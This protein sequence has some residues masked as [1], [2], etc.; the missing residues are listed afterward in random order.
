[1]VFQLNSGDVNVAAGDVGGQ[2]GE[3]GG[4][5]Q[6]WHPCQG[7]AEAAARAAYAQLGGDPAELPDMIW[8]TPLRTLFA[9]LSDPGP[10]AWSRRAQAAVAGLLR[11]PALR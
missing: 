5:H 10:Q 3:H 9:F 8:T 6:P 1:M 4:G 2:L 7:N 11:L